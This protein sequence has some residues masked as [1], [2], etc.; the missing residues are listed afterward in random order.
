MNYVWIVV[1]IV[2]WSVGRGERR[3]K[4]RKKTPNANIHRNEE[5]LFLFLSSLPSSPTSRGRIDAEISIQFKHFISV[6]LFLVLLWTR[7]PGG[8]LRLVAIFSSYAHIACLIVV[9]LHFQPRAST[10]IHSAFW[11]MKCIYNFNKLLCVGRMCVRRVAANKGEQKT[12]A[13]AH[14]FRRKFHFETYIN[15]RYVHSTPFSGLVI[16]K[17]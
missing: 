4:Q 11:A 17:N 12:P 6:R 10:I 3:G 1:S 9:K 5:N 16:T 15:L 8:W 14:K 7:S 2:E 13:N